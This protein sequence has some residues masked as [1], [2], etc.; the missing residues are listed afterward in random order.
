LLLVVAAGLVGCGPATPES[1]PDSVQ[2]AGTASSDSAY[3]AGDLKI[4]I[5]QYMPPLE[6]GALQIAAPE[7]WDWARP[8]G[9]YLVG[10]V[11]RGSELNN[12]PRILVSSDP[13]PYA[14]VSQVGQDTLPQF[15]QLV[16]AA[17]ADQKLADPVRPLILGDRAWAYYRTFA[18]R[19][20]AVVSRLVLETVV[21]DRCHTVALEVYELQFDKYRDAALAV[22]ISM[23][24]TPAVEPEPAAPEPSGE[25]GDA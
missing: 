5:G 1:A 15:I 24:F 18:K 21:D 20:N 6:G 4:A 10:F 22:A 19:K 7:N 14:G 17:V 11:P 3:Q 16:S 12:L 23:K 13:N 25:S 2:P 8:G 9:D